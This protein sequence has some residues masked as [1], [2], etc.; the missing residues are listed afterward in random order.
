MRQRIFKH[1]H[2]RKY[3]HAAS[4]SGNKYTNKH[5]Y[6]VASLVLWAV[7]VGSTQLFLGSEQDCKALAIELRMNN[8]Q[9]DW[10]RA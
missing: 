9:A 3:V 10:V 5:A 4:C 7:V 6:C 8:Q 1:K 2:G